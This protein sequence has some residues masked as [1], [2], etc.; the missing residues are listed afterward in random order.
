MDPELQI[1]TVKMEEY[2]VDWGDSVVEIR[3]V[4]TRK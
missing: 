3:L 4:V 1:W 2:A